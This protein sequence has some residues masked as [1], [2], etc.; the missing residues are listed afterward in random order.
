MPSSEVFAIHREIAVKVTRK[1]R[2]QKYRVCFVV[3]TD[4]L[5][6]NPAIVINSARCLDE[7]TLSERI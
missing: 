1:M 6:N 2:R 7:P 3:G 5:A 4:S